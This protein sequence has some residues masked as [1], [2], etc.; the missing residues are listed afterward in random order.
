MSSPVPA[1]AEELRD[2]QVKE[3]GQYVAVSP[4][5]IN[6]ARAF[7]AGD[8]VPTSHVE[9]GVVLTEQV[10]KTSTK[11]GRVAAGIDTDTPKG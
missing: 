2:A 7:N 8:A 10:A 6:G 9:R 5:D 3:Y 1:T 11:A 4:I